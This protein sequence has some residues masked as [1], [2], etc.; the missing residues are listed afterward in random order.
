M[1]YKLL[2]KLLEDQRFLMRF[3]QKQIELINPQ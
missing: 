2:L 3:L 1:K